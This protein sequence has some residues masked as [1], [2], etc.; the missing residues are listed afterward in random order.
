MVHHLEL[1]LGVGT[2]RIGIGKMEDRESVCLYP[3]N[4]PDR[5]CNMHG[6]LLFAT[7]AQADGCAGLAWFVGGP[8]KITASSLLSSRQ[9]AAP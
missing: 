9:N 8:D 6:D 3:F 7:H 4:S 1:G 2:K 5:P